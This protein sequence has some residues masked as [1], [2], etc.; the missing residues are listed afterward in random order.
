MSQKLPE[1]RPDGNLSIDCLTNFP[2][3]FWLNMVKWTQKTWIN[4]I[5]VSKATIEDCLKKNWGPY[6]QP[7]EMGKQLLHLPV[8]GTHPQPIT[9]EHCSLHPALSISQL[10]Q[11][12]K[13]YYRTFSQQH[14][15]LPMFVDVKISLNRCFCLCGIMIIR[16]V[17]PGP[18][19][20]LEEWLS[21]FCT[22]LIFFYPNKIERKKNPQ[23]V[24]YLDINKWKKK[25]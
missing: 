11:S 9:L 5:W 16:S 25:R 12:L 3:T 17:L 20:D 10:S 7:R 1:I 4:N 15:Y 2:H 24:E 8:E 23:C 21:F 22:I 14:T 6:M 19:P 18:W 13:S